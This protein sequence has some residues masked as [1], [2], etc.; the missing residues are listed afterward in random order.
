MVESEESR[1]E[2]QNFPSVQLR[3]GKSGTVRSLFHLGTAL[4]LFSAS[5]ATCQRPLFTNPFVPAGPSAPQVLPEGAP[6][7]Q[8]I[9]A[10]NQN[11]ARVRS[12]Y[13]TGASITIPGTMGLPVL[14]GN[15]AAER[16]D[17]FRLTAGTAVTGQE[18]DLG[19][20]D[21]LFWMWSRR[22]E[23]PAV[24]FCRHDQ[25]AGS[26]IRQVMPIEPTWLLAALGM[27]DI[28]PASVYDGPLPRADGRVEIRSW[29]PS[30]SG[31]LS[32]V[33]VIDARRA[34]V[35][36]QYVYDPTGSTLLAS[37]VAETHRYY[38]VEQ[39]S[40]PQRVSI[41]L[42]TA[43]LAL[44]IDLGTVTINQLPGDPRQL[45]SLPTFEGYPQYDLGGAMPDTPLPGRA[46][47]PPGA[48]QPAPGGV[49]P[50]A[51]PNTSPYSATGR[52]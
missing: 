9:A 38:P 16:P 42:P 47:P 28:D 30:A 32:R 11:S 8:I 51:Y 15:I 25:F 12:I 27:V 41:R 43:N 44:K 13:A 34:W 36:E 18:V 50:A 48:M 45:W 24:Y 5:G 29:L 6:L 33:T 37:S 10:V 4:L 2:S 1:A 35:V 3:R 52:R 40:L 20:N 23:P 26:A 46:V 7:E 39:V 21:E 14:N 17:R 49:V 19:S 22:N 31:T